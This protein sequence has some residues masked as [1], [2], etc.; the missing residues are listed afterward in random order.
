MTISDEKE[1]EGHGLSTLVGLSSN[2]HDDEESVASSSFG[3][4]NS[5]EEESTSTDPSEVT[6]TTSSKTGRAEERQIKGLTKKESRNVKVWRVIVF[7]MVSSTMMGRRG[8]L[9]KRQG[10][11]SS[12]LNVERTDSPLTFLTRHHLHS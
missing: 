10:R 3:A 2:K 5:K 11:T 8:Q 6:K 7:T 12:I 9:E 1:A 4:D